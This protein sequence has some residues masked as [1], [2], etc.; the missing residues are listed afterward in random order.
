MKKTLRS[1]IL[2]T[3]SLATAL[4]TVAQERNVTL[5]VT[6]TTDT[7]D[8]LTGQLVK[9]QQTDYQLNYSPV[10]LN[11]A[12]QCSLKIYAGNHSVNV[13]RDGYQPATTTFSVDEN[14]TSKDI[15]LRLTEKTRT[16]FSLQATLSMD[17]YTGN[18]Q[19]DLTWNT[20]KPA[21]FDDFESYAPFAITFG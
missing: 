17:A 13:D 21:F 1:F 6:V 5:N 19:V 18:N 20:E 10:A 15:T 4:P 7:G 9:V 3:L 14:A 16:P 2:L 11:A 8:D 12:G